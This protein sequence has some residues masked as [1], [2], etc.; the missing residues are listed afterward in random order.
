MVVGDQDGVLQL[1]SI[2]KNDLHISFK[3]L[4]MDKITAIQ[5]GGSGSKI[6][7]LSDILISIQFLMNIRL[8][9]MP[10]WTKFS[11]QWRIKCWDSIRRKNYFSNWK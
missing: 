1:F 8:Y 11:S 5:L 4:P 2:K 3:T 6:R 7:F 10:Q 9:C